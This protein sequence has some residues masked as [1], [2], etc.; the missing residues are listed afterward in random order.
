MFITKNTR[1]GKREYNELRELK[2][3]Y[4]VYTYTEGSVLFELGGTKILCSVTLQNSVP[5]FLRGK[6]RGWI[7]AEYAL[8]PASTPIRTVREISTNKRNG[9]TIEISRFIGRVLRSIANLSVLEEN[10]IFVDCDVMQADG[11]TRTACITAAY[12]AL[13][14]AEKKML[15]AGVIHQNFLT[16]EIA[17]ISIGIGSA[18]PLLDLDFTE[19]SSIHADYNFVLSRSGRVIEIQGIA[20]HNPI[21]WNDFDDMKELAVKGANDIFS[22]YDKHPYEPKEVDQQKISH[23]YI[24]SYR[25]FADYI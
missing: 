8:L 10:T 23:H 5:H 3:A 16:D 20:E 2:V 14:A 21:N 9:R 7:T 17:S 25:D 15:N 13:K 12:L 19:D 22:F 1:S 24:P 11:G 6:R 4:D 18:G